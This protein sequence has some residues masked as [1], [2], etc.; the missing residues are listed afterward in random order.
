MERVYLL[1][2]ERMRRSGF[3]GYE[4]EGVGLVWCGMMWCGDGQ[5]KAEVGCDGGVG[6][7]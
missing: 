2:T 5:R 4:G 7:W 6:G 1:Y 3:G